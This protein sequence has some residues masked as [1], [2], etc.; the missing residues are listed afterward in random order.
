MR[1]LVALCVVGASVSALLSAPDE[2]PSFPSEA[3]V[4][5][6][7]VVASDGKGRALDDL[8]S[9]ELRVFEDGRPCEIRSFRLV[10][11]APPPGAPAQAAAPASRVAST[12]RATA[13]P[14][15]SSLVVLLFDRMSTRSAPLARKGALDLISRPFPPDTWFAVF[16]IGYGVQ[17]LQTF[18]AEPQ[19]LRAAIERATR[20]DADK[21]PAP[22][23]PNL[24]PQGPLVPEAAGAAHL[25]DLATATSGLLDAERELSTGV[26]GLDTLYG[27]LGIARALASVEGRKSLVYFGEA[28]HLRPE[29]TLGV[30]DEAVSAANRANVAV[31]TVDVRG[32]TS[33][34]V[35]SSTALDSVVDS[36]TADNPGAAR[37]GAYTAT[38]WASGAGGPGGQAGRDLDTRA[39]RTVEILDHGEWL[40]MG[41]TPARLADDTGGLTIA[42]TN[43]LG[44]GLSRVAEEL[45]Q[46]Y[47]V[48]YV[49]ANPALDGSFRRLQVKTSRPGARIRS[50]AGYFASPAQ[51]PRLAA[52]EMPLMD[53][54]AAEAAPRDFPLH[55]GV[56]H[57][58]PKGDERECVVLAEVPLSQVQITSDPAG[59]AYR[60]HLSFLANL[61]DASGRVIARLSDDRPIE[62]PLAPKEKTRQSSAVFKGALRLAPGHYTL[63]AAVQDRRSGALSV[64]RAP[65]EI[66][67]LAGGLSLSSSTLLR[68]A[69]ATTRATS[70]DDPLHLGDASLVPS[71]APFVAGTSRELPLFVAVYPKDPAGPVE[72]TVELRR[73][74]QVVA[75][76]TSPLAAPEPDGRIPWL[77]AIPA[78]RLEAGSYDL[79]VTARQADETV[80]EHSTLEVLPPDGARPGAP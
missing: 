26:E 17:L 41:P 25:P 54:L 5:R 46:Y 43:D 28:W 49:P 14:A 61:K 15:R 12:P 23:V 39:G 18:T 66:P 35:L 21:Q 63:E 75:S 47:E 37:S 74:G 67:P 13:T 38:G 19:R 79:A 1:G 30:Y 8:R 64:T 70:A 48:I 45:R 32:L 50:R 10:R 16:K 57:F 31:H 73:G 4:V 51:A 36:F 40:L 34:K 52:R 68:R 69:D 29:R 56:L 78:A 62:G 55:A 42:G 6:L 65:F 2:P 59:D 27:V 3:H 9:D 72:L 53:A 22:S 71:L 11:S 80:E 20:G 77:G 76:S 58:A 44:A 7:D 24:R 33:H 60:G